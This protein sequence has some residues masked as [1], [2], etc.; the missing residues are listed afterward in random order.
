MVHLERMEELR[1]SVSLKA[2][3]NL[4]PLIVYKKDSFAFY[5]DL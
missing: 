4:D 5:Q 2:Y 1:D 3:A